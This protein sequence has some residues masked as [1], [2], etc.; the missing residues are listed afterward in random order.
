MKEFDWN[1]Q[2]WGPP[3]TGDEAVLR[4]FV[5]L[6]T[7]TKQATDLTSDQIAAII[8]TGQRH[9][10]RQRLLAAVGYTALTVLVAGAGYTL[11][12]LW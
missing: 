1:A 9:L 7:E 5:R 3:S 10:M 11:G 4:A 8:V 12:R 6:S 2:Y